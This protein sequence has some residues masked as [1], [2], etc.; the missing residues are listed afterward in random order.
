MAPQDERPLAQFGADQLAAL[1]A[2]VS[3]DELAALMAGEQRGAILAEIFGRMADHIRAERAADVDA[4]IHFKILDRPDGAYD[5]YELVVRDG[6]CAA[7]AGARHDPRITLSVRP[8]DFLKLVAGHADGMRLFV[9]GR[10]RVKGDLLFA[11]TAMRLFDIPRAER[12][13]LAEGA[14]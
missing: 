5:L 6:A 4:V 2:R 7:S 13:G 1:M 14:A 10:L 3:D 9:A 12:A 11:A 8:V